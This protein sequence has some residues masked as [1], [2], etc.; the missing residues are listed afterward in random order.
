MNTL[1]LSL[2]S[3]LL[4]LVAPLA[5]QSGVEVIGT[6]DIT[7]L[8]LTQDQAT[9][10]L[11]RCLPNVIGPALTP[12][13][14]GT[15][16]DPIARAT[17]I[18]DG[19]R[20]AKVDS[21]NQCRVVCP[22]QPVPNLGGNVVATGLAFNEQTRQLFICRSDNL[23]TVYQVSGYGAAGGN[24]CQLTLVS[25]CIAPVPNGHVLTG[26]ATDDVR[27]LVFYASMP[28]TT[29][30][31]TPPI[32]FSAPQSAPCQTTCRYQV[33]DCAG[34]VLRAI[35]GVGFDPCRSVVYT[36]DGSQVVGS[37]IDPVNCL[38]NPVSCCASAVTAER[39]TGLCVLPEAEQSTGRSCTGGACATCTALQH[40]LGG[41][42]V[43]GNA[44]F[45]LD[46]I[47][48]PSNSSAYLTLNV[49][50]CTTTGPT[51]GFCGPL[52]AGPSPL[53]I[54]PFATGGGG[55]ICGGS[56]SFGLSIPS[57]VSLCGVG[58]ATQYVGLCLT[59]V[60]PGTWV[61]NC[62]SWTITGS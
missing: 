62:L 43:V 11:Q 25:R 37:R 54:G 39:F 60:G 46:V 6:T 59:A 49:G 32:L 3:G 52:L 4:A 55:A 20:L 7:P 41:D 51:F 56:A 47:N 44:A 19:A 9:C 61:S 50:S 36:T 33:V 45:S 57:N 38:I 13:A 15:A 23:I 22:P 40:V 1:R 48:A 42:P 24:G 34:N 58:F 18:T 17:W 12:F 14:G 30:A 53:I 2:A 27:G 5:A 28:A 31:L 8:V 16:H 21:R 29:P 26:I 35:T 10:R